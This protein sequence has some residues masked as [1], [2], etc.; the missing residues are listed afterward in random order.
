MD[1]D[2]GLFLERT[3]LEDELGCEAG[4]WA[5]SAYPLLPSFLPSNS[6]LAAEIVGKV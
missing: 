6:G 1:R 3:Y 2:L 4:F 5:G